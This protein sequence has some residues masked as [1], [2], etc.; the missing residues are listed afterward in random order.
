MHS[1][2]NQAARHSRGF[3]QLFGLDPRIAFLM[4]LVDA[5]LFGGN[6]LTFGLLLPVSLFAGL[7]LGFVTFRAQMKW[8]GDDRDSALIKRM[9]VGLLTAI[10]TPLPAILYIPSGVL[11]LI[12]AARGGVA[13]LTLRDRN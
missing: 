11:G 2:S 5:M 12:H 4:F 3:T 8:Y 6:V 10:P 7:V 9:T 13:R 1:D